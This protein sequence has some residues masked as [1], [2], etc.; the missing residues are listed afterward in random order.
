MSSLAWLLAL[1][2]IPAKCTRHEVLSLGLCVWLVA[3]GWAGRPLLG[4]MPT[5][6]RFAID[7]SL[8][9]A[10]G[11]RL[12]DLNRDGRPDI[13]TG[14]EE[15]G[16]TRIYLHPGQ[17]AVQKAWPSVTVGKAP[18][19]EDAV[20]V[21]LNGDGR[22]DVLSS[23]EGSEQTLRMHVAP[24]DEKLL[25]NPTAWQTQV[26][27]ASR[28]ETRWMFALPTAVD[29]GPG[30][31]DAPIVVGSKAP[32]G[33]VGLLRRTNIPTA[34]A[35][36]AEWSITP[37][38]QAEWIMSL[39]NLDVDR[40]GDLDIVF[41]DRKGAESGVYWLENPDR[42]GEWKKHLIGGLG[43]EVMFLQ[44]VPTADTRP[45]SL[46]VAVKP[47]QVLWL[48]A[49]SESRLPWTEQAITIAPGDK[50]GTAKSAAAG[51]L[52]GDG[53]LEIAFSCE[54]ATQNRSGVVYLRQADAGSDAWQIHDVSGPEGIKYDRLELVDIDLDGDL[55]ILTC[56]ERQ[57]QGGLGVIWYAN[58]QISK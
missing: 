27:P 35:E 14:W 30:A 34:R 51:D 38:C 42:A 57:G 10:D 40:D 56:E 54:T 33:L 48:T 6:Q 25:L 11:V 43:M 2:S 4:Q 26:L 18:S 12:A 53:K 22:L 31:V 46:V 21:D 32:R 52:T 39:E 17:S 28:G 1:Q 47:Q 55:D 49:K 36:A 20:W 50:L 45:H 13:A 41:S 58:P 16:L 24:G 37:L 8:R 29:D 7:S 23:C 3:F 9:G 15:S 44:I 19:V 5:W